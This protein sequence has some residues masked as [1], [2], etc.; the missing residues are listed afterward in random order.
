MRKSVKK[1][2]ASASAG[3]MALALAVT[4]VPATVG[5]TNVSKAGKQ[6]AKKEFDASGNTEYHAYFGMQQ[7]ESWIFRDE[8]YADENGLNG[9]GFSDGQSFEGALYQSGENGNEPIEGA[10]VTDAVIKGNGV[11]T[12]SVEG[13]NGVLTAAETEKQAEMSMIYVNTDI[14]KTAMDKVTISDWKL[15][16]DNNT[17]TLPAD[18]FYPDEYIDESGLIS[19]HPFNAY[20]RDQGAYPDCPSV[21]TPNDSVKITF[22]VS[23]FDVDNPDA[24][25][26]TPTPAPAADDSSDSDSGSESSGG[27]GG[28]AV[29]VIVIVVIVVIAAI[30]IAL[31]K[32]KD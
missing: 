2:I 16:I 24:V 27:L 12:V 28:G 14:P 23:G 10:T 11:Y 29:A 1:L 18:V 31:K 26:E 20:Q 13:L 6:A 19:F 4:A 3:V 8:W 22:T 25:E 5:A 15:V 9:T 21:K 30:V 7:K 32:K 17:Q